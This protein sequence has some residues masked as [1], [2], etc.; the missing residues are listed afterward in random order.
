MNWIF[1]LNGDMH[2]FLKKSEIFQFWISDSQKLKC[3]LSKKMKK[4][5]H[6]V[7]EWYIEFGL[8]WKDQ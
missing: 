1:L 4:S 3:F 7:K 8:I 6:F 5:L 2:Y